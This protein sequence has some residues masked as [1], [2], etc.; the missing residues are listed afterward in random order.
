MKLDRN[1]FENHIKTYEPG[2]VVF[3]EGDRGEE[4]YV[5]IDGEVEIR[6]ST[7]S[8]SFKT[9]ITLHKGDIFGEMALIDKKA[10]SAA[11]VATAPTKLLVMNENLFEAV[12]ERNPDFAK[13]M[14]RILS[15][16]LRRS[17]SILQ[18]LITT[19]KDSQIYSGLFQ[20][21]QDYGLPTFNGFRFNIDRFKEWATEHLGMSGK[22]LDTV[23]KDMRK[24]GVIASSALGKGEVIVKQRRSP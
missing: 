18:N 19:N 22:D 11:A 12:I 8:T 1:D 4:M 13:K 24:R 6:K 20:Y 17:N 2:K 16:R 10:R 21:A 7:Y 5:I 15:E 3:Q 14:I 9:L 23:I